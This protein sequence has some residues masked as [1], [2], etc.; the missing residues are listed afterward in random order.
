MYATQALTHLVPLA[1]ELDKNKVTP[2]VLGFIVFAA[3]AV[4]VW[5]LMKSMNRHMGRVDFEEGP[6]PAE[7]ASEESAEPVS[8]KRK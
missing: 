3:L 5:L 6:G 4:G 1:E 7:P 2:G 8:A